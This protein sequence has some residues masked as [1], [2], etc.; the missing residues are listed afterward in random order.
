MPTMAITRNREGTNGGAPAHPEGSMQPDQ[1]KRD[2]AGMYYH[3]GFEEGLKAGREEA[4]R[5]QEPRRKGLEDGWRTAVLVVAQAKLEAIPADDLSK[6]LAITDLAVLI[7]LFMA[8]GRAR[9]AFAA[10]CVLARRLHG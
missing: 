7:E 5:E 2:I 4:R 1:Y 6:I 10:R 8:L 3:H 9:S